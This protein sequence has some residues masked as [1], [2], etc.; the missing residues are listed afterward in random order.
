[1]KGLRVGRECKEEELS[2]KEGMLSQKKKQGCKREC[3]VR[4]EE[5]EVQVEQT[6][7][8]KG[9]GGAQSR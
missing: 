8:F 7:L 4:K 5:R 3:E 2:M 6:T 1:M 9:V